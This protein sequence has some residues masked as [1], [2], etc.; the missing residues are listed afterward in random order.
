MKISK[1]TFAGRLTYFVQVLP[2]K[3]GHIYKSIYKNPIFLYK[4][5]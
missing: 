3:E 2:N 4:S 1:P 5:I